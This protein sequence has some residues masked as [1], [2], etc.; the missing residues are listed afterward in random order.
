[1]GYPGWGPL[2]GGNP[3]AGGGV[4]GGAGTIPAQ[5]CPVD[6]ARRHK[7][8]Q[9]SRS[10][11]PC[12]S[13]LAPQIRAEFPLSSGAHAR[14]S[15]NASREFRG[16]AWRVVRRSGA[17]S[18]SSGLIVL[19]MRARVAHVENLPVWSPG[20][21]G[22]AHRT[23][24]RHTL[25]FRAHPDAQHR[26]SGMTDRSSGRARRQCWIRGRTSGNQK[27]LSGGPIES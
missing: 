9:N 11:L 19:V 21:S 23:T 27:P 13:G 7:S 5:F 10:V 4:G 15:W 1:M 25:L 12:R 22:T 26:T 3:L 16:C 2:R 17:R 18:R 24:S 14:S 6:Q 8:G 20:T